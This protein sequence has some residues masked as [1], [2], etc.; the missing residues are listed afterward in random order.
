MVSTVPVITAR[1]QSPWREYA[2]NDGLLSSSSTVIESNHIPTFPSSPRQSSAVMIF[3]Q[4]KSP[5]RRSHTTR[6]EMEQE[7]ESTRNVCTDQSTAFWLGREWN[8]WA[9]G[10]SCEVTLLEAGSKFNNFNF[11]FL[12]FFY[13]IDFEFYSQMKIKHLCLLLYIKWES[14]NCS[15]MIEL[16]SYNIR[17]H[18]RAYLC[19]GVFLIFPGQVWPRFQI[20]KAYIS[21][22]IV[23]FVEICVRIK[24]GVQK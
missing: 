16:S 8:E 12:N 23:L 1:W 19:N 21:A 5:I 14:L 2:T 11:G 3:V 6:R 20:L 18:G 7:L 22:K 13:R 17:T 10:T 24:F 9:F 4:R 15:A